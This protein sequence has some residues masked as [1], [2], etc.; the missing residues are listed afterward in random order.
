MK[1]KQKKKWGIFL[2]RLDQAFAMAIL[3]SPQFA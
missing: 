3:L 1:R 2:P